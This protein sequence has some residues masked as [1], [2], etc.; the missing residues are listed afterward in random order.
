MTR[1]LEAASPRLPVNDC[2][3]PIEEFVRQSGSIYD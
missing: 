1:V 3:P 2:Q